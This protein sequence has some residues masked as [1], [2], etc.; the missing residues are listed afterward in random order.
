MGNREFAPSGPLVARRFDRLGFVPVACYGLEDGDQAC[1]PNALMRN[2]GF[3]FH[4]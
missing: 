1:R 4:E 3:S 2:R